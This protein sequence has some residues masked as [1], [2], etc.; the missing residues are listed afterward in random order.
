MAARHD[1]SAP[2]QTHLATRPESEACSGGE[3]GGMR[4][5]PMLEAMAETVEIGGT[6]GRPLWNGGRIRLAPGPVLVLYTRPALNR[7]ASPAASAETSMREEAWATIQP[8]EPEEGSLDMRRALQYPFHSFGCTVVHRNGPSVVHARCHGCS[9]Q[10]AHLALTS[11]RPGHRE[12]SDENLNYFFVSTCSRSSSNV[13]PT[14]T[15]PRGWGKAKVEGHG[16]RSCP[17]LL[18]RLWPETA[19]WAGRADC[20]VVRMLSKGVAAPSWRLWCW[21]LCRRRW[22]GPAVEHVNK[23]A[24]VRDGS[25]TAC[26]P[27]HQDT[28]R[29]SGRR[30]R[31]VFCMATQ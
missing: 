11:W 21:L 19:R 4:G 8:Q 26:V 14:Y 7:W 20:R 23:G 22:K 31:S 24:R 18:P 6:S 25:F 9:G 5:W 30:G 17:R 2:L 15:F 12:W 13:G 29:R 1:A 27:G 28:T 3:L 10:G 16:E